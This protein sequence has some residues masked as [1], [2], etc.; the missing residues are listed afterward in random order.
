M[1]GRFP[2]FAHARPKEPVCKGRARFLCEFL[3]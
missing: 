1:P 3:K 2:E